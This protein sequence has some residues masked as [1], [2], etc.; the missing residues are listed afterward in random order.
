MPTERDQE[1]EAALDSLLAEITLEREQA[2]WYANN[3]TGGC[4]G[5]PIPRWLDALLAVMPRLR[6]QAAQARQA[7]ADAWDLGA[8]TAFGLPGHVDREAVLARNPYRDADR[9]KGESRAGEEPKP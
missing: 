8:M 3:V 5:G 1:R 4:S 7:K 2:I 6:Q 9:A